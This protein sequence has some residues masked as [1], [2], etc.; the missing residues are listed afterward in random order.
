M[1]TYGFYDY[2]PNAENWALFEKFLLEWNAENFTEFQHPGVRV[3]EKEVE[4]S[5]DKFVAGILH[6]IYFKLGFFKKLFPY[7]VKRI[8]FSHRIRVSDTITIVDGPI[9][10]PNLSLLSHAL[11]PS[12]PMA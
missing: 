1:S 6:Y 11:A 7:F 5:E 8:F 3:A 12:A 4:T 10:T 2:Q 9:R